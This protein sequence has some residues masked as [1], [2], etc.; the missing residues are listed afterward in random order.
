MV[1]MSA[2]PPDISLKPNFCDIYATY[3]GSNVRFAVFTVVTMK[4]GVF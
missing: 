3:A 1:H 4:N 2:V